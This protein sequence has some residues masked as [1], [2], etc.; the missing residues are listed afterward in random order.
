V[1]IKPEIP[2]LDPVRVQ[3]RKH[4]L[5]NEIGQQPA[6]RGWRLAVPATALA[7][8]VVIG[9]VWWMSPTSPGL[10]DAAAV[11]RCRTALA[12]LRMP[13]PGPGEVNSSVVDRRGDVVLVLLT[14]PETM[15]FCM[16][17][18]ES[19]INDGESPRGSSPNAGFVAYQGDAIGGRPTGMA[20]GRVRPDARTAGLE[21]SD[22]RKVP[23]LL[24]KGWAVTW[25]PSE[26]EARLVT[27][28]D[29]AGHVLETFVPENR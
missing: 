19:W 16:F 8:A 10:T 22:G 2:Q 5:L 26:A 18:G 14:G 9:A 23:V 3:A 11:D 25:W 28:Y 15:W 1:N 21:T 7:A 13:W 29:E 20:Y 12:A 17:D 4:A 6:R 24:D 27:L